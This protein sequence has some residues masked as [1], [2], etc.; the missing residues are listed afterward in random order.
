MP[1][2]E[3]W[4]PRVETSEEHV[5]VIFR[6]HACLVNCRII[7]HVD[8]CT[9]GSY[10]AKTSQQTLF[11]CAGGY[12]PCRPEDRYL[13]NAPVGCQVVLVCDSPGARREYRHAEGRSRRARSKRPIRGI[14]AKNA[15]IT[16]IFSSRANVLEGNRYPPYRAAHDHVI[17]GTNRMAQRP[18]NRSNGVRKIGERREQPAHESRSDCRMVGV[19]TCAP[20]RQRAVRNWMRAS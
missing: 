10:V 11:T 6:T 19:R 7:R 5:R 20:Q 4:A 17:N 3:G 13:P 18:A 8:D 15:H 16:G 9:A 12:F 14:A 1:W 2:G